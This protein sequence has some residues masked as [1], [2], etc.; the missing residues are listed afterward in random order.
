MRALP[1][2]VTYRQL[3]HWTRAGYLHPTNGE[4]P[5][6]GKPRDWPADELRVAGII[7]EL[8]A[9][10][11]ELP[12]AARWARHFAEGFTAKTLTSRYLLVRSPDSDPP[13]SLGEPV[14][15]PAWCDGRAEIVA[16]RQ[17]AADYG[18]P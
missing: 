5:G 4:T 17:R 2:G 12:V 15:R 11:V 9:L 3:D 7:A 6:S 16:A 1:P 8:R 18:I 13:P 10:G 14:S